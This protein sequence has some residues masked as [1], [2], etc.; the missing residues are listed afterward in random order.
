MAK[1]VVLRGDTIDR[2]IDLVQLPARIGRGPNNAVVLQDPMKGVSREHAEIRLVDGRYVLVDLGSENGIWVAGRRVPEVALES[3]VIASIGPFRLMLAEEATV[4]DTEVVKQMQRPAAV[5]VPPASK[6]AAP[7]PAP[8]PPAARWPAGPAGNRRNWLAGGAVATLVVAGIWLGVG[9]LE[10]DSPPPKPIEDVPPP[11]PDINARLTDAARYIDDGRCTEAV[12]IID[13]TL[14]DYPNNDALLKEKRRAEQDCRVT[15]APTGLDMK[16]ELQRAQGFLDAGD[17]AA[18]S[19]AVNSILTQESQNAE[20]AALKAKVDK[21]LSARSPAPPPPPRL[22]VA[23]PPEKG[24]LAVKPGE[25]ERDYQQ[26][27]NEMRARYDEAIATLARGVDQNVIATLQGILDDTSPN[28]LDTTE[29]LEDA[30]KQYQALARAHVKRALDLVAKEMWDDVIAE[31]NEAKK[32]DPKLATDPA[33]QK[34][35]TTKVERG[36]R[37]CNEAKPLLTYDP[38]EASRQE[39]LARK[40]L[41]PDHPCLAGIRPK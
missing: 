41:P 7:Q 4:P 16:A 11:L 38:S 9:L 34:I 19:V 10:D 18:A 2:K 27:V 1:L 5:A 22:A 14:A 40:L 23:A 31:V 13:A 15:P 28:Y 8:R 33:V 37:A 21:C 24:G 3:N 39:R 26:R 29:R 30:R 25:L 36:V 20:A 12:Q 6:P 32:I 35:E 17:C